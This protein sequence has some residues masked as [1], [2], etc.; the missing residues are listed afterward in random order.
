MKKNY[1][2][3][4]GLRKKIN[5]YKSVLSNANQLNPTSANLSKSNKNIKGAKT[6]RNGNKKI[7]ANK[8]EKLAKSKEKTQIKDYYEEK[9]DKIRDKKYSK[10]K[11]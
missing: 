11:V 7:I 3:D 2:N 1:I 9:N 4:G 6:M 5:K 8:R 10:R